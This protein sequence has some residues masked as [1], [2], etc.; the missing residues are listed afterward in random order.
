M[1]ERTDV[2]IVGAGPSGISAAV[3]L[4]RAGVGFVLLEKGEPGGLLRNANLVENYPGFPGG[5]PGRDLAGLFVKQLERLDI[6][7]TRACVGKLRMKDG[8]YVI[9][10][11][12]RTVSAEAAIVATGTRPKA[13]GIRGE[14]SLAGRRVFY[15]IV[16]VPADIPGDR[17]IVI[18]GGGDAAFDYALNMHGRG[19][20]VRILSRSAPKALGLLRRRAGEAGVEVI[21]G[22][23]VE[24]L[25]ES[26]GRLVLSY[27]GG[28][29]HQIMDADLAL[30]ACGREPELGLLDG[31]LAA[32]LRVRNGG[33]GTNLDGMYLVGDV[34]RGSHRQTGIAVGDGI[35]AAM[36]IQELLARKRVTE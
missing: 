22:A 18:I 8:G 19:H 15:S 6:P 16:D 7:V 11:G 3:Y 36:M 35:R 31:D 1:A 17:G 27:R 9:A 34:I 10:A 2:V 13:T 26:G 4:R 20:D 24:S 29:D 33:P 32:R 5:I 21:T 23:D 14:R 12:R 28:D 30:I 25:Q